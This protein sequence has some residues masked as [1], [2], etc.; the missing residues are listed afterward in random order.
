MVSVGS[1]FDNNGFFG[2]QV[3]FVANISAQEMVTSL[4]GQHDNT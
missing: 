1:D 4:T 2:D 3:M